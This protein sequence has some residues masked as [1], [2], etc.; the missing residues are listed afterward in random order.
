MGWDGFCGAGADVG[1]C[2]LARDG[3]G[4]AQVRALRKAP[5]KIK[6]QAQSPTKVMMAPQPISHQMV[7]LSF[8]DISS[9]GDGYDGCGWFMTH[10][11]KLLSPWMGIR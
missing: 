10:L 8:S 11:T 7:V 9:Y 3:V 6:P 1:C 4:V 5:K 2:G